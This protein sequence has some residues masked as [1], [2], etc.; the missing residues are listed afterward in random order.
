MAEA[1]ALPE[2][3]L[4]ESPNS[5]TIEIF[6]WTVTAQTGPISSAT[7]CDALHAALGLPLPEMTFGSNSL[8]ITHRPSG[9]TYAFRAEDALR[10]VKNGPL[11]AG[12][13]GVKV[14]Y[15]DAWLKS[16]C[17]KYSVS[18]SPPQGA[19]RSR[20]SSR[21]HPPPHDSFTRAGPARTRRFPCRRPSPQSRTTGRIRR[22]TPEAW[23]T[24]ALEAHSGS[25]GNPPTR[26]TRSPSPSSPGQ[27]RSFSTPR[28]PCSKTSCTTTARRTSSSESCVVPLLSSLPNS[29]ARTA[30]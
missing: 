28:S 19:A 26:R 13:G 6:D 18:P 27:T 2:H 8:R 7:H 21:S 25:R 3:K 22:R 5:R 24:Q 17:A 30:P 11:E 14:L 20:P 12:D 15:A 1:V 9:W 23:T 29:K 4:S 16:R 10:E